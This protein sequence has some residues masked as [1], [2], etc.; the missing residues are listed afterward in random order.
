MRSSLSSSFVALVAFTAPFAT[1]ILQGKL[2]PPPL[3]VTHAHI[4]SLAIAAGADAAVPVTGTST[5]QQL[6]DHKNPELGTFSQQ[7][8]WSSQYWKG[9]GSPV[10]LFTPGEAAAAPYTGYLTNKTLTGLY[11]E[12]IEG[13]VVMIEH[14]YWGNSSPFDQ[15]TTKN[16]QYQTL[17]NAIADL[18]YFANNVV[19]P[20]DTNNSSQATR[21][22]WVL[23]GGSYSGALAAWTESTAPGTFWA[24]HASSAP[25]EAISDYWQYFAPVQQGMPQNCSRDVTRVIDHVDSILTTGTDAEKQALK[26]MFGLGAIKHDDDFARYVPHSR[27]T[28]SIKY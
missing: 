8:W 23:S 18:T 28:F 16:M 25:V 21:A 22:P 10:V 3:E 15:L 14:R 6:I 20:F 9:E 7:Y 24:Y 1:A 2:V 5:F 26:E 11:A 4:Q 12:A 17:E 19:L 27:R 13:A